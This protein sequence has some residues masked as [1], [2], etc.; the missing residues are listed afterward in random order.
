MPRNTHTYLFGRIHI[1]SGVQDRDSKEMLVDA[2]KSGVVVVNGRFE[3]G[4][5][6]VTEFGEGDERYV[7]GQLV[8]FKDLLEGERVDKVNRRI[9]E[10]GL[11]EGV[12]AKS[13]FCIHYRSLIIAYRPI[14]NR[15]SASQFRKAF[16]DLV[17]TANEGFFFDVTIDTIQEEI[18]IQEALERFDV[19]NRV[20]FEIHP[21]N[22]SNRHVYKRLDERLKEWQ[23]QKMQ[24]TIES[25]WGL[26]KSALLQDDTYRALIMASDGYG[27]AQVEGKVNGQVLVVSTNESPVREE[28]RATDNVESAWQ[29][30][31]SK[32]Q[33]LLDRK[34]R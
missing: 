32:I 6:E 17:R 30:L 4:F 28:I 3:Y 18:A 26:N 16:C 15:T 27:R 7:C 25:K 2:L 14:T 21:T 24:Q 22:P 12:V 34:N 8:K 20:Y 5:F 9:V 33:Q 23:A 11:D 19:V 10:D 29:Q 13:I 1:V 31:R